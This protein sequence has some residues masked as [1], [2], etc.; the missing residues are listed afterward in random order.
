MLREEDGLLKRERF[1]QEAAELELIA[2]IRALP[3]S[4]SLADSVFSEKN[5][6]AW[7]G[8]LERHYPLAQHGRCTLTLYFLPEITPQR[9]FF[10][11]FVAQD[12]S[13]AREAVETTGEGTI[14]G[15]LTP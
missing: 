11:T 14:F 1:Q 7:A 10:E 8:L 3:T 2:A 6:A 9:L 4:N 12:D 15:F 13:A 5:K